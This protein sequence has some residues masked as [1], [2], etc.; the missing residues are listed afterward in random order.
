MRD[1]QP[2]VR[3]HAGFTLIETLIVVAMLA[4]FT[5]SSLVM[6]TAPMYERVYADIEAPREAGLAT[7]LP[8]LVSDAHAAASAEAPDGAFVLRGAAPGGD[9]IAYFVDTAK[10][11]RRAQASAGASWE[12]LR[13]RAAGAALLEDIEAFS[14]SHDES[15]GLWRVTLRT[16]TTRLGRKMSADHTITV[17]V[18]KTWAGGGR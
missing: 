2:K 10:Q 14:A 16:A 17:A 6:V 3:R 4:I 11:L 18:G 12:D 15:A 13:G 9:D 1:F 5:A 7:L 8:A